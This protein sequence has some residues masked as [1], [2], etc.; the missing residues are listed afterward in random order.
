MMAPVVKRRRADQRARRY[1]ID[2]FKTFAWLGFIAFFLTVDAVIL[3]CLV[4][5]L[6]GHS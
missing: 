1:R 4:D 3:T 6:G 5:L 2:W